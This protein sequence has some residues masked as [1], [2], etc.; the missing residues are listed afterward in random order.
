MKKQR[1]LIKKRKKKLACDIPFSHN[2]TPEKK[3]SI[4]SWLTSIDLSKYKQD[5][6]SIIIIGES[7]RNGKWQD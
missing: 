1:K 4:D 2:L 5:I 3:E 6:N 7:I